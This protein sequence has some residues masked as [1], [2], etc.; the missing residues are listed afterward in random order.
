[1][2]SEVSEAIKIG[3]F[4]APLALDTFALAIALGLRAVK[5]LRPAV[6]CAIFEG[7]MPAIGIFLARVVA[8][9]YIDVALYLGAAILIVVGIHTW[10][11]AAEDEDEAE[12]VTFDSL[13]SM[14]AA[15]FAISVDELAVGFPIGAARLPI[16]T[17]LP[18]IAVQA[19]IVA[20]VGVLFG[21]RIGQRA[22]R[23]A[24][25]CAGA[26]FIVLGLWLV[27]EHLRIT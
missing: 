20:Y 12:R 1:M 22:A 6:V 15:G 21:R 2:T 9:R 14:I 4:I 3:A 27:I 23:T 13:P 19:F 26:A 16:S 10:R 8:A 18:A 24:G 11:E 17:M 25:L 7:G 5:P